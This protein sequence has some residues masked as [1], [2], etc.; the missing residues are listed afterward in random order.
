MDEYLVKGRS[1]ERLFEEYKKH[2]AL[3]IGYDFDSTV[4]DYH[5]KGATYDKVIQLLR[6][7]KSIGCKLICWTAYKDHDYVEEFLNKNTIP[8]DGIN[9]DGIAL[10]WE[11]RKPFFSALL[12]DRAGLIQVYE[13]L[14][15]LAD[16]HIHLN[17][18][19]DEYH[20]LTA[21]QMQE[22]S[23]TGIIPMDSGIKGMAGYPPDWAH[24]GEEPYFAKNIDINE[25]WDVAKP[26]LQ[27][28][29][30]TP[31]ITGT[32]PSDPN[33]NWLDE[34]GQMNIFTQDYWSLFS[35]MFEKGIPPEDD[36]K[37]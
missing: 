6:D 5:K 10:P 11:T 30:G 23:K 26:K 37:D 15:R 22:F 35:E 18:L 34:I 17:K 21:E 31:I 24:P 7:L 32:S 33:P 27:D 25:I 14:R 3:V 4:H 12:D 1:Y 20:S 2:G 19:D 29:E 28:F 13:D 8:F 16:Y 9:T 36:K